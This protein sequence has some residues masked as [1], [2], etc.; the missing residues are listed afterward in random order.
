[1][2]RT[3]KGLRF[4]CI[5]KLACHTVSWMLVKMRFWVGDEVLKNNELLAV[6]AVARVSLCMLIL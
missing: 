6:V 3:V 1:M 4:Y 5:Y 2:S